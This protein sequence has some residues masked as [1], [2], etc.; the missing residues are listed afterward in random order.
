[1][2][3]IFHRTLFLATIVNILNSMK[4]TKS[5][6]P[7]D[8]WD[9]LSWQPTLSGIPDNSGASLPNWSKWQCLQALFFCGLEP[10]SSSPE[11]SVENGTVGSFVQKTERGLFPFSL[12][13]Q[14]SLYLLWNFYLLLNVKLPW[15][16]GCAQSNLRLLQ[17][18]GPSHTWP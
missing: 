4:S 18:P 3:W 8:V 9:E 17:V 11:P 14:V 10:F 12:G 7:L 16:W 6:E 15:A 1:M 13:P 2:V 5:Y